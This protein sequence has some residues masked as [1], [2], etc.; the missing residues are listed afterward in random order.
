[1]RARH[2]AV[3]TMVAAL[4]LLGDG[5]IFGGGEALAGGKPDPPLSNQCLTFLA[6]NFFNVNFKCYVIAQG[7]NL[8][9]EV[10]LTDQFHNPG[11]GGNEEVTVRQSQ[12]VCTPAGKSGEASF[13]EACPEFHLKCYNVVPSA[14]PVGEEVTLRDQFSPPDENV[15]VTA[16]QYLCEGALKNPP[17]ED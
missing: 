17:P 8:D 12:L 1:M 6:A 4:A 16:T 2:I 15:L 11:T 3:V 14:P 7:D 10:T 13:F 9:K 5:G